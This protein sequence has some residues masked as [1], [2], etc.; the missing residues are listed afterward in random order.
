M[1]DEIPSLE[2]LMAAFEATGFG[3][4]NFG[5]VAEEHPKLVEALRKLD[6]VRTAATFGALLT[7]P[8]LQC[9]CTRLEFLVHLALAT[10]EV[11][12]TPGREVVETSFVTIGEGVCGRV[13]DPAEDVFVSLIRTSAGP[14]RI[15]EGI[16]ESAGFFLQRMVDVVEG[17]PEGSGYDEIREVVYSLLRLS[18]LVCERAKLTRYQLGNE[19]PLDHILSEVLND[20]AEVRRIVEFSE[21]E[22]VDAGISIDHLAEFFFDPNERRGLLTQEQGNSDLE[23]RPIAC[24]GGTVHVVLPTA[25]SLAIRRYIFERMHRAGLTEPLLSALTFEYADLLKRSPMLGGATGVETQFERTDNGIFGAVACEV[26]PGR[27]LNVVFAFDD[28]VGFEEGSFATNVRDPEPASNDID[29]FVQHAYQGASQSP[30]YREGMTV[31]VGC[32]IGRPVAYSLLEK[33]RKNWRVEFLSAPDFFTLCWLPK[34]NPLALWRILD[35]RD[36]LEASDLHLHNINGLLNLVAWSRSL[37][38]HLVPHGE[39]PDDFVQDGVSNIIMVTQNGN[40]DIRSEVALAWDPHMQPFI[41]GQWVKVRREGQSLFD[42]DRARP[43]Y[44]SEGVPAGCS[45]PAG[46]YVTDQRPWWCDVEVPAGTPGAVTYERWRVATVW[47]ARAAPVL[48]AAFPE[49][50]DGPLLWRTRYEGQLSEL[51]SEEVAIDYG[52][53]RTTLSFEVDR[54]AGVLTLHAVERYDRAHAHPEN[55]AERALVAVF[56]MAVAAL[57]GRDLTDADREALVDVIVPSPLARQQHAF[58]RAEFRDLV[59][60]SLPKRPIIIEQADD[61]G[62]RLGLGW[63]VRDRSAGAWV[64]GKELCMAFLN[65]LVGKLTDELIADVGKFDRRALV[66]MALRNHETAAVERSHWHRTSAAVLALHDDEEA[67]L[68]KLAEHDFKLNAAFM[69]SRTLVEFAL[70]EA[71]MLGGMRPGELDFSRLMSKVSLLFNIGGWSDAIRWNV[72]QPRLRVTP[73]GDVHANWDFVEAVVEP[74]S[75]AAADGRIQDAVRDYSKNIE[76]YEITPTVGDAFD[77]DFLRAF[78]EEMGATLDQYRVFTDFIEDLGYRRK[79]GVFSVSLSALL[80]VKTNG[81]TLSAEVAQAIIDRL[82]LKPRARWKETP[83]GYDDRDRFPWRFRRRLAVL[84]KPLVQMD[85]GE[86]PTV[87][88]TPGLFREALLYMIGNYMRGDF[89]DWQLK[90]GMRRWAGRTADKRG[91]QFAEDV[92]ARLSEAGWRTE[93]DIK[94]T[95]LLERSFE[96]DYGDVDVFAYHPQSRRVLAIECKDVQYRKTYGEVAEQLAE[97]RGELRASGKPDYLLLHLNRMELLSKH[98]PEIA[99]YLGLDEVLQV[100]SHLVFRNPVPMKFALQSMSERVSVHI[101]DDL[102]R[103]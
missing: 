48:E 83:A 23:R 79:T 52:E 73:L 5:A 96:Y 3:A 70:C 90:R 74:F 37:A 92:A 67:T 45:G 14:F 47:L 81:G 88:V 103:I 85:E 10:G 35:A 54:V 25:I 38:G 29:V 8:T 101:F 34:F 12:R 22:L 93:V 49:L 58:R 46:V 28:L 27:F 102:E 2:A 97:F 69:A 98:L 16:W 30:S 26:D 82:L 62:A 21:R 13:E 75:R 94:V 80:E 55:V 91:R 50:P 41:D 40:R 17:L 64:D 51:Q 20:L 87:I 43:I 59:R 53:A 84:R 77:A 95:K 78:E 11:R 71:P 60:P 42:E 7:I 18:D 100:E 6:P 72:M 63:K 33:E 4:L 9:N 61:A 39:I 1:D 56:V 32:G 31:I 57:A 65:Q 44:A 36:E 24:E 89:P 76:P 19:M 15:L 99:K 86:D 66:M 68:A